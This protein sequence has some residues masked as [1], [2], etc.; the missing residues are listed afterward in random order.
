MSPKRLT[1]LYGWAA[2][3]GKTTRIICGF[4]SCTAEN[5]TFNTGFLLFRKSPKI[6][7]RYIHAQRHVH[8]VELGCT[9]AAYLM[10]NQSICVVSLNINSLMPWKEFNVS[11]YV[12]WEYELDLPRSVIAVIRSLMKRFKS[13]ISPVEKSITSHWWRVAGRTSVLCITSQ[14]PAR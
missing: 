8:F 14:T 3:S 12:N 7:E 5:K 6:C 4:F 10:A 2:D 9:A 1:V 11:V 13:L